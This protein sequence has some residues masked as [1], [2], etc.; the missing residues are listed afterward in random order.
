MWG[1]SGP[2]GSARHILIREAASRMRTRWGCQRED[3][4]EGQQGPW[5]A[6]AEGHWSLE[7][8]WG[9]LAHVPRTCN[10]DERYTAQ[11]IS[12]TCLV[13]RAQFSSVSQSCPTV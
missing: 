8:Q 10:K 2:G 7:L 1:Q 9:Q 13:E 5:G 3:C 12:I 4:P 11:D 6:M